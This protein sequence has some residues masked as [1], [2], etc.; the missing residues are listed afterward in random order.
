MAI[1]ANPERRSVTF[2]VITGQSESG[3][4]KYAN[5]SINNINS[6]STAAQLYTAFAGVPG[7][8]NGDVS[9]FLVTTVENVSEE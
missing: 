8:L 6:Q 1:T 4:D 7:V 2:K 5:R 9:K 3:S